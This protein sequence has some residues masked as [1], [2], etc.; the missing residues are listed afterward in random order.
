MKVD[1]N[2][3][4]R[5]EALQHHGI[6]CQACGHDPVILREVEVHHLDPLAD[7]GPGHTTMED[8]AVLCRICHARAHRDGNTDILP[9]ARLREIAVAESQSEK[10]RLITF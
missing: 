8:V 2:P 9:V 10:R 5:R 3:A 6:K 4:L 1:D 7:R